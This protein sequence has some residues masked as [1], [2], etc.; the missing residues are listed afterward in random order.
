M[1]SFFALFYKELCLLFRDK[2][3]LIVL[4]IMPAVLV[5]VV[6]C[7]QNVNFKNSKITPVKVLFINNDM[8]KIGS[9]ITSKL[10]R[11]NELQLVKKINGKSISVK[12]A[13]K[14][15]SAGKYHALLIIP[16]NTSKIIGNYIESNIKGKKTDKP[17]LKISIVFD[18]AINP[19]LASTLQNG[20][21]LF[22]SQIE[23]HMMEKSIQKALGNSISDSS[24]KN[25]SWVSE[26]YVRSQQ[27]LQRP[28]PVQQNVPAWTLF[29]MFFIVV[30]LSGTL[31]KERHS[32]VMVRLLST[33]MSPVSF[34]SSKIFAYVIINM[35]QLA[36]MLSMGLTVLPWLGTPA[37]VLSGHYGA[38]CIIGIMASLAA[39]GFGLLVGAIAKS[40]HQASMLGPVLIVIAAAIGGIM[41]PSYLMPPAMQKMIYLSPLSWG[42]AAFVNVLVRNYGVT[43]IYPQLCK[44]LLFFCITFIISIICFRRELTRQK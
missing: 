44:L 13:K 32:S 2:F 27:N 25:P 16:Q 43:Q 5:V 33:P 17:D 39:T 42:H 21:K 36:V 7:V 8:G 26:S 9:N 35:I 22:I 40:F 31:I 28:N 29:G 30:P 19:A 4:F 24:F 41:V 20:L 10:E 11:N 3:G 15:L 1:L 38:I 34:L 37:L 23:I 6:T 14:L 12:Q 18:P